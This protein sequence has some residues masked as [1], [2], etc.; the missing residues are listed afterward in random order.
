MANTVLLTADKHKHLKVKARYSSALGDNVMWSPTYPAEFRSVQADYPILFHKDANS[1]KFIPAA[2]FGLEQGEN[3]FLGESEQWDAAYI[4]LM[5]QRIPFSIGLY[6]EEKK[7]LVN[8][9]LDHP[10]VSD[11]DGVA[12]FEEHGAPTEYLERV[13]GMLEA[14]HVWVEH[15]DKFMAAVSE[16][17]LLEPVT[18]DITLENGTQGQLMGFYAVNEDKLKLLD[19]T[20][21]HTFFEQ[22]FLEPLYMAIAS[23]ANIR[24][25]INRKSKLT[26]KASLAS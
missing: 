19:A 11:S 5:M 26:T 18:V 2:L 20:D 6:G 16:L 12:L 24:K 25:L 7:R 1:E 22:D 10:K 23:V 4:P 3:L 21:F 8:I 9:D 15:N 17:N 14:I 13:S